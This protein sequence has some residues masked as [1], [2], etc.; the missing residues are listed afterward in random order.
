MKEIEDGFKLYNI[1]LTKEEWQQFHA[2]IDEN[3]DGVL[4]LEEWRNVLEPRVAAETDYQKIMGNVRIDDP[5]TLE[6]RCLDLQYR[7]RK[8]E[9][10]LRAVKKQA[11]AKG[12]EDKND[13]IKKLSKQIRSAELDDEDRKQ[14]LAKSE[15]EMEEKIRAQMQDR[16]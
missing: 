14:E 8:L 16:L 3:A 7:N 10:D 2:A 9:I 15:R 6:E 4:T 5:L 1:N 11:K 12:K 13:E